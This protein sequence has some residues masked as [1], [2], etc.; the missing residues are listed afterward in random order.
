VLELA[1]SLS[2][3]ARHALA[4]LEQRTIAVDGGRLKLEWGVLNARSGH[5]VEDVLWWNGDRLVGFVGLYAFGPPAVELAGM[6]DPA[7]RR[8]G[9]ATALL[10]AALPL[11][12]DRG[13]A[14]ALLVTPRSSTAGH[15]FAQHRGAVLEHSEHALVLVGEPAEGPTNPQIS[16]RKA[17]PADAV[18]I[19]ALF[20]AVGW[21]PPDVLG[22]QVSTFA[23]TMLIEAAGSLIGTV[24]V[25][26]EN[27]TGAVYGFA[28]DP[29][30]QARGVGRDVLRRVCRQL[31]ADGV[32]QV[33]LEV[34]VENERALGLYTS[35]GFTPT[36]AEDYYALPLT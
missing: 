30:W 3:H 35:I 21:P 10:D 26:R 29:A 13:Y 36:T 14:Q 31:R 5:D 18:Q 12:R 17:T 22:R 33:R 6:V 1:R 4:E 7:A 15:C 23:G 19:S 2:P 28:V 24:R 20:T 11:C 25:E 8:R 9:V 34:T 32:H 16:L 27:D